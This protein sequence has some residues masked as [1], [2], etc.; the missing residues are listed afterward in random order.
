M[1]YTF[2]L[3]D[4][5]NLNCTYCYEGEKGYS[6]LSFED[7]KLVLDREVSSGSDKCQI[8]FFG[9]EPLLKKELIYEVVNYTK[10]LEN[11]NNIK[12]TY[13]LT[14]NGTLVDREFIKFTKKYDFLVGYSLDGK[15]LT[16][17]KNRK[18]YSGEG[19]FDVVSNNAREL[20]KK[21]DK[22]VAMPVITKN[23]YKDMVE[24]ARYLFDMGFRYVN[25]AFDYTADWTDE[26]IGLLRAEYEKLAELYYE[27]TKNN[28]DFYLLPFDNK[29]N[30]YIKEKNC[31][32]ECLLAV[33][34][35]NVS[36]DGKIY[37][38]MQFVGKEKYEI[39]NVK[40]G[41][42][43]SK[44]NDLREKYK[45]AGNKVCDECVIRKRCKHT[46]GCLNI[47]TT[48]DMRTTSP[49]VCETERMFIEISDKL[50]TRIYKEGLQIFYKKKY[51][52]W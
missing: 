12:F 47:I 44:L 2:H 25:C 22:I 8:S 28:N 23:N 29:I 38:C 35:V 1:N 46:C 40:E 51:W 30:T 26:D 21:V 3:T 42:N 34:H 33:K 14:T 52:N 18:T 24:N 32:E 6:E 13:G 43:E 39:G 19:T 49:L 36:A 10:D 41:I 27:K 9:G 5:C 31:E 20:I 7:I 37:P 17:N 4:R 45:G 11:K 16:Q 48:G 15:A 50:V